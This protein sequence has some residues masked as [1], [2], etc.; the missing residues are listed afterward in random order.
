MQW[1]VRK[2]PVAVFMMGGNGPR[3]R[4]SFHIV[5]STT[6][7]SG[8]RCRRALSGSR[9]LG[10]PGGLLAGTGRS[11]LAVPTGSAQPVAEGQGR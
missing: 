3:A 1:L 8:P 5:T 6:L 2:V 9:S 7:C 4:R 10:R 11:A